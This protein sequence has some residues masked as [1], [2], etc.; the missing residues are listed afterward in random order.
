MEEV[1]VVPRHR[2]RQEE[3]ASQ[4]DENNAPEYTLHGLGD[5]LGRISRLA[6]GQTNHLGSAVLEGCE[7]KHLEDSFDPVREGSW[8]VV[9][10]EADFLA[11]NDTTRDE[12][13]TQKEDEDEDYFGCSQPEFGF[14]KSSNPEE[15]ECQKDEP[16]ICQF[17]NCGVG[18]KLSYQN[19]RIQPHRGI[20][21][22][23]KASTKPKLSYVASVRTLK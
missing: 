2:N 7:N 12:N 14:S 8:V 9:E 1:R 19:T 4:K 16:L 5:I 18:C 10:L 17:S 23:Q 15:G 21:V 6:S 11:S 22:S 20:A 13:G 3:D